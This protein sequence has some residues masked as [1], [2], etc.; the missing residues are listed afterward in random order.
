LADTS[1]EEL[2]KKAKCKAEGLVC[3][4]NKFIHDLEEY[5]F[6]KEPVYCC[7]C[8]CEIPSFVKPLS[9]IDNKACCSEDCLNEMIKEYSAVKVDKEYLGDEYDPKQAINTCDICGKIIIGV[10][11]FINAG[12]MVVCSEE[13]KQKAIG[14]FFTE[15]CLTSEERNGILI[16]YEDR[17]WAGSIHDRY[18]LKG[19]K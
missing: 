16:S 17:L 12:D 18:K 9:F 4:I 10:D 14:E 11:N 5:D 8:G 6:E 15:N 1:K 2:I 7:K 13:C 19:T 3:D